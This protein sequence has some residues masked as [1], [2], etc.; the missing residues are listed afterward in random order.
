MA[1]GYKKRQAQ[2][3]IKGGSAHHATGDGGAYPSEGG[4]G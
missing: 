4:H 2:N 3:R 1:G